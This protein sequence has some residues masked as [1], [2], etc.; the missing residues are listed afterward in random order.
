MSAPTI[1]HLDLTVQSGHEVRAAK[2]LAERLPAEKW[3]VLAAL[4]AELVSVHEA[5]AV[6]A[7][8]V[9][10]VTDQ[11]VRQVLRDLDREAPAEAL[12]ARLR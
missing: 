12:K 10:V 1:L 4:A 8:T 7:T 3:K 5:R 11:Q 6:G 2:D 9:L